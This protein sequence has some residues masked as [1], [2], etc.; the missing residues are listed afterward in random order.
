MFIGFKSTSLYPSESSGNVEVCVKV[1]FPF[2][3]SAPIPNL[4]YSVVVTTQ[5]GA[6]P[7]GTISL[8]I[9]VIT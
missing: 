1:I 6:G 9:Y 8:A 2:N 3:P 7:I 5:S 4:N